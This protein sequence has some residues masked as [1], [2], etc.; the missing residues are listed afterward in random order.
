MNDLYSLLLRKPTSIVF[1]RSKLSY[2]DILEGFHIGSLSDKYLRA[3]KAMVKANPAAASVIIYKTGT[4][5]VMAI[6]GSGPTAIVIDGEKIASILA[7]HE[8]KEGI[9]IFTYC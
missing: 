7:Q 6:F 8:K 2:E 1:S 5:S 3:A 9:Y 4:D